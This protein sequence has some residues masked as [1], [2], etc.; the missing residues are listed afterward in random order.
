MAKKMISIWFFIGLLLTV[1]GV[2]ILGAGI[3]DLIVPGRH[4]VVLRELHAGV[5][6]GALLIVIGV[7]YLV[8]FRPKRTGK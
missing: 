7:V 2:L 3:Y 1:Y 5:W 6:W 4:N 8:F